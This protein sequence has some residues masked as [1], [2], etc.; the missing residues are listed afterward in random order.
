VIGISFYAYALVI[1]LPPKF[2]RRKMKQK[3]Y[4][5]ERGSDSYVPDENRTLFPVDLR[6]RLFCTIILASCCVPP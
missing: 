5:S 6:V 3:I 2:Q 1:N 4:T